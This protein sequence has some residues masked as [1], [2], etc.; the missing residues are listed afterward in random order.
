MKRELMNLFLFIGICFVVY[1]LF[2][3]LDFN[4]KPNIQES[5]SL[6]SLTGTDTK[7]DTKS[8]STK[9]DTKTDTPVAIK[10]SGGAGDTA[11]YAA[12][13]KSMSIRLQDIMLISKYRTDY[14]TAIL[15]LDELTNIVMLKEV[16]NLLEPD[17]KSKEV[18]FIKKISA[19][20]EMNKFKTSLN[21]IM[22]FVDSSK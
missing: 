6:G 21:D 8:D 12:Y 5:F 7:S 3:N 15:N 19:I 16:L 18:D 10:M 11:G 4:P 17:P 20:N 14:E 22:K 13:I 1:I 2:R 9:S